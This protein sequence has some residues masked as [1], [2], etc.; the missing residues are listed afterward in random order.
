MRDT[1]KTF[2]DRTTKPTFSTESGAGSTIGAG[3]V[4]PK[5]REE[6]LQAINYIKVLEDDWNGFVAKKPLTLVIEIVE[7]FIQNIPLN[8]I[9]PAQLSPDGE[10]GITLKWVT[11]DTKLLLN[12][13][14]GLI[15]LAIHGKNKKPELIDGIVYNGE[16]IIPQKI[17]AYIPVRAKK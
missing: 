9:Y 7:Q 15:N 16:N 12:F 11:V 4:Y 2:S 5:E 17:L 10:G 8:K 13:E 14:P 6:L 3:I 1:Y